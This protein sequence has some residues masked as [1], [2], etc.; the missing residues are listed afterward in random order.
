MAV[1]STLHTIVKEYAQTDDRIR[2]L[3]EKSGVD[4][5]GLKKIVQDYLINLNMDRLWYHV[6]PVQSSLLIEVLFLYSEQKGLIPVAKGLGLEQV[7]QAK[8][9]PTDKADE[10]I[11]LLDTEQN[12]SNLSEDNEQNSE[13]ENKN[14][15]VEAFKLFIHDLSSKLP[16][17]A[18]TYPISTPSSPKKRVKKQTADE[19]MDLLAEGKLT[20]QTLTDEQKEI[21]HRSVK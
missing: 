11:E 20:N 15:S 4:P 19:I 17:G 13:N 21:L 12:P 18:K 9:K 3:A 6:V 14:S 1:S 2:F 7:R 8:Y 16:N 5:R 10:P